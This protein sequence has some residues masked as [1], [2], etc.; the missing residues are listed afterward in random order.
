MA[1][2]ICDSTT[3]LH[4]KEL[5]HHREMTFPIACYEDDLNSII[6]PWHWHDEW[7]FIYVEK[8]T[9]ALLLRCV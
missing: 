2:S 6:V 5:L 3:D 9:A 4:Q 7:E 8:G 1:L